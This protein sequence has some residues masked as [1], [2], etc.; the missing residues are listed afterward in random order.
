[1]SMNSHNTDSSVQETVKAP[2]GSRKLRFGTIAAIT[3]VMVIAVVL[4]LN[5]VMDTLEE[6]YPLTVD[7]TADNLF[8]LDENSVTLAKGIQTPVEI[9]VFAEEGYFAAPNTGSDVTDKI[10]TQFYEALKQYQSLS[11]GK[12]S[13]RFVDL[14]A[15]PTLATKY[16]VYSVSNGSILFLCGE[17]YQTCHINDLYS[18]EANYTTYTYDYTSEVESVLAAKINMVSAASVK[19]AVIL[20][21]HEEIADVITNME[22]MLSNNGCE[23]AQLDITASAEPAEDTS[24]FIIPGASQDYTAAEIAKLRGW[25]DNGGKRERDLVVLVN[26]VTLLPNLQEMLADEY[27]I[28]VLDQLV[29]ETDANN[30]YDMD[31]YNTYGDV[32]DTDFTAE[33]TGNR[34]LA[35]LTR[36]LK[37][38]ITSSTDESTYAKTLYTFGETAKVQDLAAAITAATEEET[39][40]ET[41]N[42]AEYPIVGAAYTTDRLYDNNDQRYYTTDVMVYGTVMFANSTTMDVTSACNEDLFLAVFRGL[43]GLESVITVS[44]KPLSGET[45]D[46]GGSKVP[47]VLGIYVFTIGL[48]TVLVAIAIIVFVR[49]RRL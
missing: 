44:D 48:P 47:T 41:K 5:V 43:T 33:L 31:S 1:M 32:A 46:F 34:V 11:G 18:Y 29:C 2:R 24:V 6:R 30:V 38:T 25:L 10:L 21:G 23:V 17:R 28:E 8:T 39:A 7:L 42:A 35:P 45:L 49:R 20:V 12:V 14:D 36:P 27:G 16:A 40:I 13:Y 9:V 19:K 3:T 37:V 22:K 26:P 4:L 15:N